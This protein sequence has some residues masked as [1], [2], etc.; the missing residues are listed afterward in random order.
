MLDLHE[1]PNLRTYSPYYIL[2]PYRFPEQPG[3]YG[4]RPRRLPLAYRPREVKDGF[5][6]RLADKGLDIIFFYIMPCSDVGDKFFNRPFDVSEVV[7]QFFHK[8]AGRLFAYRL[9]ISGGLF[10]NITDQLIFLKPLED[11]RCRVSCDR[12]KKITFTRSDIL[13]LEVADQCQNG[14]LGRVITITD[15]R[16]LHGLR[17]SFDIFYN[18]K[19]LRAYPHTKIFGVGA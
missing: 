10:L 4:Y 3:Q 7:S 14:I 15:Y 2:G 19:T 12:R 5:F 13:R 6:K 18:D 17:E 11:L 8:Q 16:I 1:A 9:F